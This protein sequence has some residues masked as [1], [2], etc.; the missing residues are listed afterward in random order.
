MNLS[1]LHFC[2]TPISL[3]SLCPSVEDVGVFLPLMIPVVVARLGMQEI[4]EPSEELRLSLVSLLTALVGLCRE[5]MAP[6]LSDM[7]MVLQNTIVDPYPEVKKVSIPSC[8][9]GECDT[10]SE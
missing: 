9:V 3:C 10:S 7:V 6:Y 5:K 1:R 8:T 2:L 4:T